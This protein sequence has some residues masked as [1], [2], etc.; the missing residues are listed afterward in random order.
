M[1]QAPLG[2]AVAPT[3]QDRQAVGKGGCPHLVPALHRG[4]ASATGRQTVSRAREIPGIPRNRQG[5]ADPRDPRDPASDG[6][7]LILPQ[8]GQPVPTTN[9]GEVGAWS[10]PT[11]APG[12][13]T[14]FLSMIALQD[15]RAGTHTHA[16]HQHRAGHL[17]RRRRRVR[18]ATAPSGVPWPPVTT[19]P[20]RALTASSALGDL[21]R[22]ALHQLDRRLRAVGG[23]DR[24]REVVEVEDRQRRHTT[25]MCEPA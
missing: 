22:S 15:D 18:P 14:T 13:T 3:R 17:P 23:E 11:S 19:T 1:K 10:T 25:S 16:V 6:E 9:P 7:V 21:A 24:P 12:G 20:A 2:V 8:D 4:C 5:S